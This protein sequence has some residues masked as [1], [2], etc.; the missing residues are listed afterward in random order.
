[1]ASGGQGDGNKDQPKS[2]RQEIAERKAE[3]AKKEASANAKN[4][5]NE[6]G[7]ASNMEAQKQ[8]QTVV[9]QAMSFKPGFDVYSQQL[10]VQTPFY[11]PVGVYKNQQTVDNRKLGRGLFGPTDQLHNEMVESQYNRGN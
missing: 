11:A 7:K 8:M 9:I 1:M 6:M 5:A 2:A 10:I 4:L 3:V